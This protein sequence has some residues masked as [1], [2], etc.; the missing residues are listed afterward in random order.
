MSNTEILSILQQVT[1]DCKDNGERF[2]VEHRIKAIESLLS[3]SNYQLLHRGKLCYI[4]GK[5]PVNGESIVLVSSHIDCVYDKLFCKEL[6]NGLI[7]G[8]FDNSIT[9]SCVLHCML[10]DTLSENVIIAFT[11][12]EEHD[13]G[14]TKEVMDILN[15]WQVNVEMA[16]VTDTTEAGW[17]SDCPFTIENDYNIDILTGYRIIET[18]KEID[19]DYEYIHQSLPDE[20]WDYAEQNIPCFSL[21]LSVQG[22]LHSNKGCITKQSSLPIYCQVLSLLC[23]MI[24]PLSL[25]LQPQ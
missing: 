22:E 3:N 10:T 25:Y 7:Q 11:G 24:S 9:N 1:V 8:T 21:C 15:Q 13:S 18:L 6:E 12:D 19:S 4:Y 14:G 20:T 2:I 16:I 5:K 17:E 23:N